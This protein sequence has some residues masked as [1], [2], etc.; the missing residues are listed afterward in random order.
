[1]CY[2]VPQFT[3]MMLPT[4]TEVTVTGKHIT[5]FLTHFMTPEFLQGVTSGDLTPRGDGSPKIT[6]HRQQRLSKGPSYVSHPSYN[7]E[8]FYR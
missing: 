3:I 4:C 6:H 1:M 2:Q 7:F 5:N 8:P